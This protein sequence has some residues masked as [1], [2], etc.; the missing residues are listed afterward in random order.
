MNFDD[1]PYRMKKLDVDRAW[2]A[3]Q[4]DYSLRTVSAILAPNASPA[5][6]TE[7]ALRRIWE[8]LDREEARQQSPVALLEQHQLVLRPS[9]QQF[10]SW[11]REANAHGMLIKDWCIEALNAAA[12]VI[13]GDFKAIPAYPS[14]IVAE[15]PGIYRAK[16]QPHIHAAAGGPILANVQDWEGAGDTVLVKINGLSMMPLLND[17]DVI[18][19]KHKRAS[20]TPFVAKG[21]IYLI[22]YDGGYTVKRYNTR[23]ATQEEIDA[24]IAY[25]SPSDKK[26]KVRILQSLNPDFPDIVLKEEADWIAWLPAKKK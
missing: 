5:N 6:K 1:I 14:A 20:S 21:K 3:E 26:H 24:G 18:A 25:I 9:D 11:N 22:A 19:M 12:H 23:K 17:G 10:D 16:S 13:K 2:L 15:E 8:A 7:K 4:C